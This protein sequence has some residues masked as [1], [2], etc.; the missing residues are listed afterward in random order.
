M[1]N[2]KGLDTSWPWAYRMT[3]E[4]FLE[5]CAKQ[6]RWSVSDAVG[7]VYL[8]YLLKYYGKICV[9]S[10]HIGVYTAGSGIFWTD[11]RPKNHNDPR[12]LR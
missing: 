12:L 1:S 9:G 8:V 5:G 4:E 3:T 6:P 11:R 7:T 10:R 2:T